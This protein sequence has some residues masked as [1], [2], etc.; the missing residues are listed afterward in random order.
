MENV[1]I[2]S[3]QVEYSACLM[4]N[5][6]LGLGTFHKTCS[7]SGDFPYAVLAFF[8]DSCDLSDIPRC[9][10]FTFCK[11]RFVGRGQSIR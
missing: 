3:C 9:H 4:I 10:L 6:R 11:I 7:Y 5:I 1:C 8:N 2:S